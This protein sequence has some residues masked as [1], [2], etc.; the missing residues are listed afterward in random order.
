M[1]SI[2]RYS[3]LIQIPTYTGRLD[4][5]QCGGTIG[6][7]TFGGRRQLNQ[8]LYSSP[9]WK[10]FRRYIIIRDNGYDMGLEPYTINDYIYIH[11]I[12]PLTPEDIL[13]RSSCIFDEE[14]VISVSRRSHEIIHYGTKDDINNIID[15]N[16]K[17][18]DTCP[19]R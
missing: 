1:S 17:P 9:E 10:R 14:N 8:T 5:L 12:E 3:E 6:V 18:N 7:Q 16:R 11:H 19:W 15:I 13:R 4:Y 2:K